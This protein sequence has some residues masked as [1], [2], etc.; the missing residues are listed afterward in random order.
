VLGGSSYN[1]PFVKLLIRLLIRAYKLFVSPILHWM[2]GPG[3]G[4]RF[5]PTCSAYF[6]AAVETH[7]CLRGVTLGVKRICRCNP[8][9]E[10]GY[11]PVPPNP[12]S[13]S[14]PAPLSH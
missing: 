11:D 1:S 9:C 14:S 2:A 5:E 4:C 7:G 8:W 3:A 12:K 10:P 13:S 6:L